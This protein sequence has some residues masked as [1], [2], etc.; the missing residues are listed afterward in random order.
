MTTLV[1][2]DAE[3]MAQIRH[4]LTVRDRVLVRGF[5]RVGYTRPPT[6]AGRPTSCGPTEDGH[7]EN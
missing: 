3:E 5:W 7:G 2:T 6:I 4:L 1:R